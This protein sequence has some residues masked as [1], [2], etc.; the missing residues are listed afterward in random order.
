MSRAVSSAVMHIAISTVIGNVII[1]TVE[2]AVKLIAVSTGR[3]TNSE[4]QNPDRRDFLGNIRNT[5]LMSA[6][7]RLDFG[8][9]LNRNDATRNDLVFEDGDFPTLKQNYDRNEDAHHNYGSKRQQQ[10]LH[11]THAF[12][13]THF[14]RSQ[15]SVTFL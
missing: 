13:C 1:P 8:K 14:F 15:K 5:P 6:S 2:I 4:V 7:G 3:G 10:V 12:R 9:E 11:K